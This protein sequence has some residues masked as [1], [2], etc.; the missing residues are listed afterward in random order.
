MTHFHTQIFALLRAFI[1]SSQLLERPL[2]QLASQGCNKA[3]TLSICLQD[4]I[5]FYHRQLCTDFQ[6]LKE[7]NVVLETKGNRY[8]REIKLFLSSVCLT[9]ECGVFP[10]L[11]LDLQAMLLWDG[12][13]SSYT[14][15]NLWL[16]HIW[17]TGRT[18]AK[19]LLPKPKD[20]ETQHSVLPCCYVLCPRWFAV[21]AH[22]LSNFWL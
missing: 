4:T 17:G 11:H 3:V 6:N 20:C 19:F 1:Y 5:F 12:C 7:K 21:D 16:W 9:W 15:W 10:P 8:G 14:G 18:R 13:K 22:C 2:Q